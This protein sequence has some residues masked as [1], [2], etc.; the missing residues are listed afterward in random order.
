MSYHSVMKDWE[1]IRA[2]RHDLTDYVIH[3]TK[4]QVLALPDGTQRF[5]LARDVLLNILRTGVIRPTFAARRNRS[6]S[7]LRATIKGP[8]AAVCLTEQ[9]LW[10]VLANRA[11][12]TISRYSGYG[13]AFNKS[14]IYNRGARPV[15]YG[16]QDML[17]QRI[18]PGEPGYE[19]GKDIFRNG[20][21][22]DLQWLWVNYQ[23]DIPGFG[24]YPVDFTWEREWRYRPLSGEAGLPLAIQHYYPHLCGGAI[25]V[26][27][28]DDVAVCRQE[29]QAHIAAGQK[30]PQ[31][32]S[33]VISLQSVERQ[34]AAG[35]HC[36]G[37]IETWP[38]Q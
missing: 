30:W 18:T 13:I 11:S 22:R 5:F 6:S 12:T 8:T 10:A 15:I 26:E 31:F 28:D 37:R 3:F 38:E 36:Y 4:N 33:R 29:I 24:T 35:Q 32:L 1:R 7:A 34:L 21:P 25:L 2:N 20:L 27:R 19:E 16:T 23:P 17:G 14:L 9:P